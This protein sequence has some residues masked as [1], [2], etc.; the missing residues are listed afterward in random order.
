MS[1]TRITQSQSDILT[2]RAAVERAKAEGLV[3]SE[4][5][6][7]RWIDEEELS[8]RKSGN[9]TLIYYPLLR[10]YLKGRM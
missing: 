10:D 5:A 9:R 1:N 4:Y 6:V 2:I 3:V 8:V 7:R